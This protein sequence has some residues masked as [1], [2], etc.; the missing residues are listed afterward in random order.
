MGTLIVSQC[1]LWLSLSPLSDAEK[2]PFL[3]TPVSPQGIFWEAVTFMTANSETD[4]KSQEAL[5]S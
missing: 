1:Y 4:M 3:D 2:S 5:W